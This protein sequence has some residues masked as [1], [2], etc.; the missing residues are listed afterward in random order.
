LMYTFQ[1]W[2]GIF[3]FIFLIV[4]VITTTGYKYV[5]GSAK[6]VEYAAWHDKLTTAPYL[7]LVFYMVGVAMASY[8]LAYGIWNFGIRW[9]IT[10]SDKAQNTV[11]KIAFGFFI[12]IT[13]I[14]WG[15]LA[16]FLLPQNQ[17]TSAGTAQV[18]RQMGSTSHSKFSG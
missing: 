13:L 6:V 18:M 9:G 2:S 7:W 15:A 10:V 1:R 8:H 4:H 12:V 16:G 14:G 5:T 11:Q 3:L 17:P